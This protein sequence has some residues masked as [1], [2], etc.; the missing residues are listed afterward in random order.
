MVENKKLENET[1]EEKVPETVQNEFMLQLEDESKLAELKNSIIEK[2]YGDSFNTELWKFGQSLTVE[3]LNDLAKGELQVYGREGVYPQLTQD[4]AILYKDFREAQ[5]IKAQRAPEPQFDYDTGV[6]NKLLRFNLANAD[7]QNEKE[8]VLNSV[9]GE[10]NWGVDR[11]GKYYLK[12]EGLINIGDEIPLEEGKVGRIIDEK[13]PFSKQDFIE[14]SAYAPQFLAAM[15]AGMR[16][17]GYGFV[18]GVIA[19]GVAEVGG[20]LTQELIEYLQGY[21][22]QPF[23]FAEGDDQSM[24]GS[25]TWNFAY[26]AGG[27]SFVRFLRPLGRMIT[28]PQSGILAFRANAPLTKKKAEA[29]INGNREEILSAFPD[30]ET[31]LKAVYKDVPAEEYENLLEASIAAM[32]MKVL[33][34][35][36]YKQPN[37]IGSILDDK[38]GYQSVIR[39]SDGEIIPNPNATTGSRIPTEKQITVQDIT[40]GDPSKGVPPGIPSITQG[41]ERPILGRLQAVLETVFGNKRDMV[42]R[43]FLDKSMLALRAEAAGMDEKTIFDYITRNLLPKDSPLYLSDAAFGKII[44]KQLGSEKVFLNDAIEHSSREINGQLNLTL[45]ELDNLTTLNKDKA[46]EL[47]ESLSG[48]KTKYNVRSAAIFKNIDD[49]AGVGIFDGSALKTA[50]TEIESILPT[51][52]VTKTITESIGPGA[53]TRTREVVE[54]VIDDTLV[55]PVIV[56]LLRGLKEMDVNMTGTNLQGVES[57]IKSVINDPTLLKGIGFENIMKL[58]NTLDG[59]YSSGIAKAAHLSQGG[60]GEIIDNLTNV[61]NMR[62]EVGNKLAKVNGKLLTKLAQSDETIDLVDAGSVFNTLVKTNDFKQLKNLINVMPTEK[63]A[64]LKTNLNKTVLADIIQGSKGVSGDV[65]VTKLLNGWENMSSRMKTELF[66]IDELQK[67]N[68]LMFQVKGMSGTLDNAVLEEIVQKGGNEWAETLSSHVAKKLELDKFMQTN[69][70]N[71]LSNPDTVQFEQAI[72]AIFKPQSSNL[73]SQVLKHFEG[74]PEII[75]AIKTKAM[76]KILRASIDSSDNFNIIY[77]GANLNKALEKY[78]VANLNTMFGKELTG[79][80]F[81]FAR[82]LNLISQGKGNKGGLVAAN[83]ALAPLRKGVGAIPEILTLGLISRA[84][85]SKNVLKYLALG[86]QGKTGKNIK[87][88]TENFVRAK[89]AIVASGAVEETA[90]EDP[91]GPRE[92]IEEGGAMELKDDIQNRV[93]PED[94]PYVPFV[95]NRSGSIPEGS[96][97]VKN[98]APP[99]AVDRPDTMDRGKELFK[100]DITFAAQGGIMNAKKAFQRV[101]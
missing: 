96:R 22:N 42:N 91:K 54:T 66:S 71:V 56:K 80:L 63:A 50:A 10:G 57:F 18:P 98:M 8:L 36:I 31:K 81:S 76:E 4:Q 34:G 62:N 93:I 45:K 39:G 13:S 33:G 38:A 95:E 75:N 40:T 82:S 28:D 79:D 78:G 3:Q 49:L 11:A 7:T 84:F 9:V 1:N 20:Y 90:A 17:S 12:E 43:V 44:A 48:Y 67:I 23:L 51:K 85:A 97:M 52:Q 53:G 94:I 41:A 55:P 100:N 68:S 16:F 59:V 99:L 19:S 35:D 92:F 5:K 77:S 87:N 88:V 72:D 25:A 30:L 26:G 83:L 46:D 32:K 29:L 15:G 101:A 74:S 27:E 14:M 37:R 60:K 73:T 65:N 69:W 64:L 58:N 61:L 24:V 21:Q 70:K 89:S 47:L 2:Y 86:L 6:K